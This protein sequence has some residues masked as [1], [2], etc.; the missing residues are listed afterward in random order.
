MTDEEK[1]NITYGYSTTTSCS[2][3][4]GSAPRVGFPGI[5]LQDAG[6]GVRDTDMVNSY[7]SGIYV[8]A[9]WNRDLVYRRGHYMGTEFKRK[10]V[11]VAREA[12]L[13]IAERKLQCVRREECA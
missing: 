13:R 1:N 8:G 6:N 4:S 2:G 5:C 10:S 11:N 3:M 7:P 12:D 9:S